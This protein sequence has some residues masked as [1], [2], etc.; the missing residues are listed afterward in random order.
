MPSSAAL[1]KKIAALK[2]KA[3]DTRGKIAALKPLLAAAKAADKDKKA[4]SKGK[5]KKAAKKGGKKK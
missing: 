2:A 4:S 5:A 3:T 1:S